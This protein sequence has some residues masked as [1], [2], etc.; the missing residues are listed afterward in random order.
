MRAPLAAALCLAA[1]SAPAA[2]A[3]PTAQ[4]QALD[5]EVA[6][7]KAETLGLLADF[8]E[9]EEALRCP[10]LECT[11][12]HVTVRISGFLLEQVRLGFDGARATELAFSATES[13]ALLKGGWALALRTPLDP[14]RHT[15][16]ATIVG[17]FA[18]MA[19]EDPPLEFSYDQTVFKGF[20][21]LDLLLAVELGDRRRSVR[22]SPVRV[23]RPRDADP[24]F[25]G[26]VLRNPDIALYSRGSSVDPKVRNARF[27]QL[28]GRSLSAAA[29]LEASLGDYPSVD[30]EVDWLRAEA[31]LRFG[32]DDA[33]RRILER[34]TARDGH[35]AGRAAAL[36][37]DLAEHW[38]R[39]G[40][41]DA[42]GRLLSALRPAL[43]RAEL[44][45]WMTLQSEVLI[46]Q[47]RWG[48]AIAVLREQVD[49]DARTLHARYNLGVAL[50]R[51]GE[52]V[53]GR[54]ELDA[55]GRAAVRDET[56]AALRDR[57]NVTLGYH[58]LGRELGG[59]AKPLFERVRVEGPHSNQALLGMGWA[60]IAPRGERQARLT[61]DELPSPYSSFSTLGVLIR[62]GALSPEVLA[63]LGLT[64]FKQDALRGDE[65]QR[66]LRAL[67][68]WLE[69]ARRDP[70]DPAVQEG[71]LAIAQALDQLGAHRQALQTYLQAVEEF[72]RARSRIAGIRAQLPQGRMIETMIRRDADAESGREWRVTELADV[73]E[74]YWLADLLATHR[75]QEGLRNYRDLRLLARRLD[76]VALRAVQ[77][78]QELAR[79][80][81]S[82][83]WA[84]DLR[85]RQLAER[86]TTPPGPPVSLRIE[87]WL[88]S[89][90]NSAATLPETAIRPPRLRLDSTM[91][92]FQGPY[93]TLRSLQQRIAALRPLIEQAR[94][95]QRRLLD[96]ML[97][98]ELDAQ[99]RTL[100]RYLLEARF[101]IARIYDRHMEE[102]QP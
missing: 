58:F 83:L 37:L 85:T 6:T 2:V 54:R 82:G 8:G 77:L 17:R 47:Q 9:A 11:R 23:M 10:A 63:R 79:L 13:R 88:G 29:L 57:A 26:E 87:R 62:P 74:T 89:A 98:A 46:A 66:L 42:A 35:D 12:V 22:L 27:L 95:T 44:E 70:F 68:P 64:S 94:T 43:P 45:R 55:V 18:D 28:D 5:R 34:L 14:G 30:E 73:P 40:R 1:W 90:W 96:E 80:R 76:L 52:L 97:D 41:L 91:P 59:T 60:E 101:A 100:E 72:E 20:D 69:L 32:I 16:R 51:N 3:L 39:R 86:Y 65:Q 56:E 48:D 92:R 67:V 61:E 38:Y 33:A 93:E 71:R 21:A 15:L 75:L 19:A 49:S 99:R 102:Q 84:V 7:L 31:L 24:A 36:A 4:E 78:P 50:L 25:A 53:E 81:R